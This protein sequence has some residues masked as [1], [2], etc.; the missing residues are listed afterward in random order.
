MSQHNMTIWGLSTGNEPTD[1][2]FGF[3]IMKFVTLGFTA[4]NQVSI[5][6]ILYYDYECWLINLHSTIIIVKNL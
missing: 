6:F 4:V 2:V 3:L 1:G 5:G